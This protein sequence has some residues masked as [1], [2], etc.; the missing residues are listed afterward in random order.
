MLFAQI[1]R[2]PRAPQA[3][4]I[5]QVCPPPWQHTV[6]VAQSA[7]VLQS[8]VLP[9]GQVAPVVHVLEPPASAALVQ[10]TCPVPQ[11]LGAAQICVLPDGHAAPVL[12]AS[13]AP[14][15]PVQHTWPI[16]QSIV[17]MHG[18]ATRQ[19]MNP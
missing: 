13:A 2:L 9:L 8:I 5:W 12:H 7:V 15:R 11:S 19:V 3:D 14:A 16:A 17:P 6:P 18:G 1:C 10:Q 4:W